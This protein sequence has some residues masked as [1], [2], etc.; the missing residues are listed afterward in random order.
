M[1]QGGCP[2]GNGTGG[3]GY[4]FPDEIDPGLKHDGPGVLSMANAGPGTNGSQFFITHTATPWL[5]GKHTVFGRVV[6]GQDVV[7][8][9]RQ[10]DRIQT[11][12]I[13]RNGAQ[14]NAF[15]A[16]QAAFDL[17]RRSAGSARTTGATATRETDLALIERNY[18]GA[19]VRPSGLRWIVQKTGSGP[20]PARG[21]TV[22]VNLKGSLLS[23]QAFANSDLT[24][25]AE[26]FPV[27]NGRIIPG[28]DEALMDMT[29]G[30]KRIVI[31]PPELAYGSRGIANVIPPNSFVVFELEVVRIEQ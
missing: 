25:G 29:A 22:V 17:L 26:R 13:V 19:V 20:K 18:S 14:A 23:G 4:Q 12:A 27:G 11:I 2:I 5:D 30:E 3:P 21:S 9:I 24:G 10:G 31:V 6:Q 16:D 28:L 8:R 1:I 7:N 15:R